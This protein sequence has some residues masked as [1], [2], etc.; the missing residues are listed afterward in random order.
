MLGLA[1]ALGGAAASAVGA[2]VGA[3]VP[4]GVAALAARTSEPTTAGRRT[5]LG[6][7]AAAVGLALAGGVLGSRRTVSAGDG[8]ASVPADSEVGRLLATAR[9]RSLDVDG[10]EPLV[11]ERFYEVDINQVDP[12]PDRDEW[13]LSVTGAVENPGEYS[14]EDVTSMPA[15]HRFNTLRCVGESLN[16]MKMDNALWTGTPLT[17]ILEDAG[18]QGDYVML[19]AADGFYEEFSV[20]ALRNGFLAWGM[21][22]ADLPRGHGAPVRA[23]IPGHWGEINVKWL[24]EIEIL[25]EEM[26]GYWEERGWHGTGPVNTVAKL[27]AVNRLGDGRIEVGGHAYAGTRGVDRVEVSVDGGD[28]WTDA[29]LSEPLPGDDVWRQWV[30]RYDSPGAEH[31][32]VVRATDGTGTLQPADERSAFPNGPS[33]WVSRTVRG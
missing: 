3:A 2:T 24:T 27:H 9:D 26:E 19:R 11:S 20:A 10:I 12:D 23:L 14:Y 33:G 7:I 1:L 15:E 13:T 28:T 17:R 18:L 32:V 22:G 6:S 30:H 8:T 16:G 21:N 5:A 25:D 29:E 4:L 31:E